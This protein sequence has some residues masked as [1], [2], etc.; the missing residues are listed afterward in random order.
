MSLT[1]V[2]TIQC[3]FKKCGKKYVLH[4][5]PEKNNPGVADVVSS[6]DAFGHELFF[7]SPLHLLAYWTDFVRAT[8]E[9]PLTKEDTRV[10]AP[11]EDLGVN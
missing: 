4:D 3:D 8:Q 2:T 7:C 6:K 1:S 9:K 11:P 10:P 5:E